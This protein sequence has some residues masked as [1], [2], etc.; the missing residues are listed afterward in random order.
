M[1]KAL[2]K[3]T[4]EHALNSFVQ[5]YSTSGMVQRDSEWHLLRG[6]TVGG[7]EL[8]SILGI[9]PY[10]KFDDV[11]ETKVNILRSQAIDKGGEP[12][13]WGTLFE[14]VIARFVELDLDTRICGTDICIQEYPGHRY[15]PDGYC[16]ADFYYSKRRKK[17]RLGSSS[18]KKQIISPRIL[19]LEFKCPLRR[20]PKNEIPLYYLPQLWSGLAVSPL[21][22]QG[23]FVDAL[24]R[25][26]DLVNV[27]RN[28]VYS[29][30][31]HS[32]GP[33][34]YS[35]TNINGLQPIAWGIIG[36]YSGLSNTSEAV[37]SFCQECK[38]QV[39]H[40]NMFCQT[41][42][43]PDV[44]DFGAVSHS[45]FYDLLRMIDSKELSTEEK[46]LCYGDKRKGT[47]LF[48]SDEI[49]AAINSL[50]T[51]KDSQATLIGVIPWKLFKVEYILVNRIPNFMEMVL[52]LINKV[53]STV[54]ERISHETDQ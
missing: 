15:S 22:F 19:L 1:S 31:I 44:I 36:V 6:K 33:P 13:W 28:S 49:S 10:C 24:F 48:S 51:E 27:G 8:A 53:H 41:D 37:A 3:K 23:L 50:F 12:C 18:R 21:A 25:V 5:S 4:L 20:C 34:V 46:T 32:E 26:C 42:I 16:V 29:Q 7:S 47:H 38:N 43:D 2:N 17:W 30:Q 14:K 45:S 9:N 40:S 52:P 39:R 11:V 54:Q 35:S